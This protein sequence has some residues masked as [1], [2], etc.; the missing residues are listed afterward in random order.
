MPDE[1]PMATGVP[2]P[3]AESQP[4]PGWRTLLAAVAGLALLVPLVVWAVRSLGPR[5]EPPAPAVTDPRIPH[6]AHKMPAAVS[7]AG[8]IVPHTVRVV[9]L[10]ARLFPSD[11]SPAGLLGEQAFAA[12]CEDAVAVTG[13]LSSP[14]YCYLIAYRADGTERLCFPEERNEAPPRTARPRYPAGSQG[15]PLSLNE[16]SGL[17]AFVLVAR[18][19]PLLSYADWRRQHGP[20]P[21]MKGDG[22]VGTVWRYDGAALR[23]LRAHEPAGGAPGPEACGG[24][25]L[26]RLADWLRRETEADAVAAVAFTV[27]PQP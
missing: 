17:H 25:D 10:D 26:R 18:L 13:E 27:R 16:G 7:I 6:L 15:V 1:G 5:P 9:R 22:Q 21:W 2:P 14:A 19:K 20:A 3:P 24:N 12:G 8:P 11:G 4:G 23:P